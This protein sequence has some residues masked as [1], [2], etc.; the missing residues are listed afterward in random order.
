M[1]A[2]MQVL[3]EAEQ[4]EPA[5]TKRI[6]THANNKGDVLTFKVSEPVITNKL[7]ISQQDLKLR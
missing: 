1:L 3:K 6:F 5:V 2:T 7:P 4:P